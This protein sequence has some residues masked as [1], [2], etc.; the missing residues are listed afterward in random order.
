MSQSITSQAIGVPPAAVGARRPAH[1][2][3]HVDIEQ[4]AAAAIAKAVP[5]ERNRVSSTARFDD[6][7]IDS[8]DVANIALALEEEFDIRLPD[9]FPIDTLESMAD[10]VA[11]VVR[12]LGVMPE[13]DASAKAP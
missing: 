1:G 12:F 10:A 3:H 5:L 7:G 4:R 2:T 11:V 9:D 13:D 6:L 8:L